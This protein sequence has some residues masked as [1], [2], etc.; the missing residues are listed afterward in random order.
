[1]D[2]VPILSVRCDVEARRRQ[3]TARCDHCRKP[4][5]AGR[6]LTGPGDTQFDS[7]ACRHKYLSTAELRRL[8]NGHRVARSRLKTATIYRAG[9]AYR[10]LGGREWPLVERLLRSFL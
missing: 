6:G 4:L 3:A 9:V 5:R 1:M 2:G 8:Q 10:S 7:T